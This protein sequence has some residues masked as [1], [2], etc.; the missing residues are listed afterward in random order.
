MKKIRSCRLLFVLM[1]AVGA[2]F[3]QSGGTIQGVV[4][5]SSGATLPNATVTAENK[6]TGVA[7]IRTTNTDGVYVASALPPGIYKLQ[8]TA[9][10]FQTLVQENITVDA[11]ASLS[12]NL[13]L[14]VGNAATDVTVQAQGATIQTEDAVLGQTTRNEVYAALPLAMGSGVPRDPTQFIAL[15]PG[16]AAV[17]TQSAGPSYT[18]FNGA[19][20]ETNGLYIEG[21]PVT[22]PNQQGDTRPLALGVS[23]EAV[24]Q[25]QVEVNG[26]KAQYQGQ[27]FH[28]YIMKTG[29]NAFHGSVFEYFRNTALDA[30]GFFSPFVPLDH[31]NEFGGNVN[32]PII[33]DKLFFFSNYSGYYFNTSTAPILLNI[34]SLRMRQGDFGELPVAVFDPASTNCV[35][36]ICSRQAFAGNLIP[37]SRQSGV[38]RSFQSYLPQPTGPGVNSNYLATLPRAINNRNTT[39]TVDYVP[40]QKHR[41]AGFFAWG[42]WQT[43]YTGNLTPTG[44]ALPLPYTSSPGKVVE[45]PI[46]AQVRETWVI[47]PSLLNLFGLGVVR[48]SIP[49]YP[50]T[51]DGTYPQ[52]AGLKGLPGGGQAAL[53]FP[54]INFTGSNAPGSWAGTGPFFEVENAYVLQDSIQWV[55]KTHVL[56]FG[57][58]YQILQDNDSRPND[59]TSASFTFLNNQTA[60]FSAAGALQTAT[61]NPYASYLLGA[62]DSSAITNNNVVRAGHRFKNFSLYAQ[63]DYKVTNKLKLNLG[64]RWDVFQPY[65]EAHNRYSYMSADLQNPSAGNIRGALAYGAPGFID[66]HWGS[67]QPRVGLAYQLDNKTVIR[68]GFVYATTAGGTA[69]LGGNGA[70]GPGR[71]GYNPP[72]SLTSTATGLPA[73]YWDAGV[74]APVTP[75]P[76]LTAG[77]GAGNSTVNPTGAISAPYVDKT[78]AGKPP[79]Y[80]NWSLGIQRELPG[81]ITLG[82]TYSASVGHFLPRSGDNG[83]FT[84]SMNPKYLALGSLLNVQS[85]DANIASARAVFSEVARPFSTFTGT[86]GNMLRP[87]PQYSAVTCFSCNLGNSTYNSMQITASRRMARGLTMQMNYTFSKA[88][89]NMPSGGQLGT[90]GGTRNPY[91]G[92]MDRGLGAIDHRHLLRFTSVYELPFGKGRLG[93]GNKLLSMLLSDWSISGL[94]IYTTGAPLGITSNGCTTPGFSGQT[95]I[96]S[97]APGFSGS[98]RAGDWGSGNVLAPGA[99]SYL[100]RTAFADAAPFTFGNLARSAPYGLFAPA[101]WNMDSTLRRSISI[102]ERVKL[103][104][105]ADVFNVF[106]SVVFAAPQTNISSANFGQLTSAANAP[107]RIQLNARINF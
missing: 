43:D 70:Q 71:N 97:Y 44:T 26:Q 12:V 53:G 20:Q 55:K 89:D 29:G 77:F 2:M 63:D 88:I 46:I 102:T 101:L 3:A 107:R 41:V 10:G 91:D 16:V 95:C 93:G 33:K 36:A 94:Y 27:G 54:G 15:A 11:L 58:T 14:A 98:A 35:G 66:T 87:F 30:R 100:N 13:Q 49:I 84:N 56:S 51:Q 4:T 6:A 86:I 17:V 37:A 1:S 105:A 74:P 32:G 34:P 7:T 62:P 75:S 99:T 67:F 103:L 38:S 52:K 8:A 50:I 40:N 9:S 104:L 28:N 82:V 57:G 31:Q 42:K 18:S 39:N 78:M 81:A 22:F 24:D 45:V 25:F 19:Q 72:T 64:L 48:L 60:G 106:N 85:T 83:I 23:V 76:L 59:G 21:L 69:G 68:S 79:Y 61:G 73:F 92:K 90:V 80:M 47:S 65:G 96:P 5:D